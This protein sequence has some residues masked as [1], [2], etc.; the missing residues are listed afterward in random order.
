[1]P[2]ANGGK[3]ENLEAELPKDMR[4]LQEQQEMTTAAV[5]QLAIEVSA[6]NKKADAYQRGQRACNRTLNHRIKGL[7]EATEDLDE[8]VASQVEE[9]TSPRKMVSRWK[10]DPLV[11]AIITLIAIMGIAVEEWWRDTRRMTDLQE[12]RLIVVETT[13]KDLPAQMQR[14]DAKIDK[15]LTSIRGNS[16]HRNP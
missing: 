4:I 7:E 3:Y 16:G 6:M 5:G 13:V 14:Q 12:K 15:I 9:E 2:P 11:W 10:S 1:M 8:A